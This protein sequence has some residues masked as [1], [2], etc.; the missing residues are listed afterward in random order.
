MAKVINIVGSKSNVGKTFV[1]EGLI[2]ELKKRNYKVATIKHDVHGF[3]IDHE[4]KDTYKHRM[5]GADTVI[6]SSKARYA[7]IKEIQEEISLEEI[8]K[9]II[10]ENDIILVEGYKNSDLR[11]IEVYNTKLSEEIISPIDKLIAIASD[12]MFE[13]NDIAVLYKEDFISLVDLIEKEENYKIEK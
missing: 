8:I 6:I 12:E 9:D 10:D 5:A 11:K 1:M 13:Y 2:K 3:D 7:K 4:G